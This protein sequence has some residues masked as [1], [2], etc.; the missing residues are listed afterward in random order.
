MAKPIRY[1][2]LDADKIIE[3]LERLE[4]RI[5]ERFPGSGLSRVC[6]ELITVARQTSERIEYVSRPN[7]TLRT[8]LVCL[9]ASAFGI[10]I[11]LI[12]QATAFKGTDEWSEALQGL[13]AMFNI[14]VL[15]GG[16]AFFISTLETRWKRSRALT[17]LH[18]LRSIVHVIDMHQLTKDPSTMGVARTSNSPDRDLTPFSLMRYLDYCS[19][20]LSMTAKCAALYAESLSDAVVVDTVGDIERLTSELSSKIWQK[21]TMVQSLE[22]RDVPGPMISYR[23][24]AHGS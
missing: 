1:R 24:T 3:T 14:A 9:V 18:E 7:W 17:A 16:A 15:L 6:A 19:E 4:H 22:D 21:I 12:S 13:D 2:S 11:Y 20:M 5:G 23:P 8:L 10:L